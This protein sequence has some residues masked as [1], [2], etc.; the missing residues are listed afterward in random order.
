MQVQKL[1]S[2]AIDKF[3]RKANGKGAVSAGNRFTLFISNEDMNDFIKTIK[4][5]ENSKVCKNIE[6]FLNINIKHQCK[7]IGMN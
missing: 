6:M 4:S 7:I 5:L 3:E 2:N 1:A